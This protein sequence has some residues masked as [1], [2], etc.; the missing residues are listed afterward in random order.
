LPDRSSPAPDKIRLA[1]LERPARPAL[2]RAGV[3]A[4]LAGA[5]W[6][7]QAAAIAFL[8][9]RW[10]NGTVTPETAL[11]IA[12]IFTLIG[13]LRAVLDHRVG[14]ITFDAADRILGHERAQLLARESLRAGT[15]GGPASAALAAMIAQKL[16]MLTPYLTRYRPAALRVAVL[17]APLLLITA[18]ISW[19]AALI[20]LMTGPL[21]PVFMALVGIAA[22]EASER[23]LSEISDMNT[24]LMDRLGALLDIRLLDAGERTARDFTARAEGLQARTLAV[25]RIAFLSSS[26]LELFAALGVAMMAVYVGFSLLGSLHFGTWTGPLSLAQG[27]FLLLLAPDYFQPLRD[28]AA[29]WHDRAAAMAVAGE[30]AVLETIP[31]TQVLGHGLAS[32]PLAGVPM[33]ATSG[34]IVT[35]AGQ[36]LHLP[37]LHVGA[38]ERL[39]ITGPSGA[40]KSTLLAVLAGI[41]P[42]SAGEVRVAGTPLTAENADAWR[43]RLAWAAQAP[44]FLDATLAQ[45]LDLRETGADLTTALTAAQADG[46]VATLPGG[47]Q[48]RLGETGGGISGGE[49][50]RLMLAR[51]YAGMPEVLLADEP[52]ADLDVETAQAVIEG[53][54]AMSAR[55]VTLIV[56]THDPRLIAA[57]GCELRLEPRT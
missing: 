51:A 25:L 57:L 40:G 33:I 27:I 4:I 38:G 44:H 39:A 30:L 29:A 46:V 7:L 17:P 18:C 22:K 45:N 41:E 35:R 1:V 42:I 37:D 47:L 43:A 28:L 48:A 49:A 11:G 16:P 10:V 55:G 56:A 15:S 19:A 36:P 6:P 26:V 20:L 2:R 52:T 14:A 21:I 3:L 32:A 23:Q 12:A 5:L 50:R 34:I 24:L 54:M 8:V 53:L 13:G 31:V 9:S